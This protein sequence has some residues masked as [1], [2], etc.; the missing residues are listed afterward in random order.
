M[1]KICKFYRVS[2][3]YFS[4]ECEGQIYPTGGYD[5]DN[6]VPDATKANVRE[7]YSEF[8]RILAQQNSGKLLCVI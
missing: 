1:E 5:F 6:F 8:Y 2:H 7:V 3:I 4:I